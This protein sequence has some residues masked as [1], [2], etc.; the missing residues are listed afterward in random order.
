MKLYTIQLLLAIEMPYKSGHNKTKIIL[1][2]RFGKDRVVQSL[3]IFTFYRSCFLRKIYENIIYYSKIYKK[4][5]QRTLHTN[6]FIKVTFQ[7]PLRI[8]SLNKSIGQIVYF[9]LRSP[10]FFCL[11]PHIF[12]AM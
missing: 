5:T 7:A 11:M 1:Y 12:V 6:N 2:T 4:E 9:I 8:F 10:L 3:H